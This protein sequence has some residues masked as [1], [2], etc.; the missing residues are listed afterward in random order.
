[1][2]L[3]V[4]GKRNPHVA[5][6]VHFNLHAAGPAQIEKIDEI[7]HELHI[8]PLF[9]RGSPVG[10]RCLWLGKRVGNQDLNVDK[11]DPRL[12]DQFPQLSI[13]RLTMLVIILQPSLAS[14]LIVDPRIEEEAAQ[15]AVRGWVGWSKG[16]CRARQPNSP[17]GNDR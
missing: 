12:V 10:W 2:V 15:A 8:G 7:L 11:V 14:D 4:H 16:L 9:D 6:Q 1:M 13:D 5:G 3:R 17:N